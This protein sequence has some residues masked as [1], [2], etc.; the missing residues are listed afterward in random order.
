MNEFATYIAVENNDI[1]QFVKQHAPLVQKIGRHLAARLPASVQIDDLVQSGMIGLLEAVKNYDP[2]KGASFE[3]YAGIRIRGAMLDEIRK[4]DWTPRS[5]HRNTRKVAQ[6]VRTI[7]NQLGRDAK[8]N[9][10]AKYLEIS[11]EEYNE[12]VQDSTTSRVAGFEDIGVTEESI[13]DGLGNRVPNPLDGI[14]QEFFLEDLAQC[15][16]NLPEKERLVI[17][18]YYDE[19]LNLREIGEVLGVTESRVCQIHSQAVTRLQTRL[20]DWC[21]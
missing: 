10:I 3:T 9:E 8:D 2:S 17:S 7:E 1:N 4:G 15:I 18:L 11:V 21:E 19:E 12:M 20:T 5:V 16:A 6:A 14:S 13:I